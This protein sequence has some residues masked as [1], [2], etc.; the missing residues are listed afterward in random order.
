[1]HDAVADHFNLTWPC[2]DLHRATPQHLKQCDEQVGLLASQTLL[3]K[4]CTLH[5][6]DRKLHRIAICAPLRGGLPEW[7]RRRYGGELH[8][9]LV[10]MDLQA[11]GASVQRHNLHADAPS[12][13]TACSCACSHVP[14]LPLSSSAS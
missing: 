11:A 3:S 9:Q 13:S 5:S 10:E 6:A 14:R 2:E 8:A 12:P 4:H 1:M 7:I